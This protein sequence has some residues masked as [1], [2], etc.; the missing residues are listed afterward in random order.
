MGEVGLAMKLV[1]KN[2]KQLECPWGVVWTIIQCLFEPCRHIVDCQMECDI[3]GINTDSWEYPIL[4][5][6]PFEYE[7]KQ[8]NLY[9]SLD[10]LNVH[11]NN[12]L[13]GC[14]HFD[15]YIHAILLLLFGFEIHQFYHFGLLVDK[16]LFH[17]QHVFIIL[18]FRTKTILISEE[19]GF[20]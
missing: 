11:L 9:K 13:S 19:T 5:Q 12:F 16:I 14:P 17:H 2:T 20:G 18:A 6:A 15:C 4:K 10:T 7:L 3:I 8:M 1:T